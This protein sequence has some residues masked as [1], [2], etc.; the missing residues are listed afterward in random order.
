MILQINITQIGRRTS[1]YIVN[2]F[3]NL[4]RIH[5]SEKA[6][7]RLATFAR[8][9]FRFLRVRYDM[10]SYFYETRDLAKW[11]AVGAIDCTGPLVV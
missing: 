9:L 6:A 7:T 2:F 1:F 8:I 4:N 11:D 10:T 5:K 3:F